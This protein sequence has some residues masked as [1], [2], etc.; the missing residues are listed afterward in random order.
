MAAMDSAE[1][2]GLYAAYE[3]FATG[4]YGYQGAMGSSILC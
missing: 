4:R 1:M 2:R 3:L